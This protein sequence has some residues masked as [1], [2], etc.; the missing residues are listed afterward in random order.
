MVSL[1]KK[2]ILYL[3]VSDSLQLIWGMHQSLLF[4]FSFL[5]NQRLTLVQS[6]VGEVSFS[7]FEVYM[8]RKG[9]KIQDVT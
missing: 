8:G 3:Q 7:I 2:S 9:W 6:S 1:K 5:P 4:S